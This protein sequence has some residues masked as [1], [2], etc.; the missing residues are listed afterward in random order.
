[1]LVG[2]FVPIYAYFL[3]LL[4]LFVKLRWHFSLGCA[5]CYIRTHDDWSTSITLYHDPTLAV[6]GVKRFG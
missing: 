5:L 4:L 1:M 6:H 3:G 2:V